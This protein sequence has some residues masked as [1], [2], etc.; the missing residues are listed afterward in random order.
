MKSSHS[1]LVLRL[2]RAREIVYKSTDLRLFI[3]KA[4]IKESRVSEINRS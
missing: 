4:K 3:I 2:N 1:L